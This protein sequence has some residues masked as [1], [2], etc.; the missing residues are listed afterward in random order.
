MKTDTAGAGIGA[1]AVLLNHISVQFLGAPLAL[2]VAAFGGALF[3]ATYFPADRRISRPWAV[4][5]NTVAGVVLATVV[6]KLAGLEGA[7]LSG[8][9]FVIA[10]AP[11][12]VFRWITARL[13]IKPENNNAA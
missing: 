9:G 13:G 7:L 10:A 11:V 6:A 8:L 2:V 3:G 12:L 4:I 1:A 5:V